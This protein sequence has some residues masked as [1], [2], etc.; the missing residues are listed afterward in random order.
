[1]ILTKVISEEKILKGLLEV[2]NLN[3]K[4]LLFTAYDAGLKVSEAVA[5][6]VTDIDSDRMQIRIATTKGKK[7]HMATLTKTTLQILTE[8]VKEYQPEKYLFEGKG[9]DRFFSKKKCSKSVW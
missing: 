7:E 8:Y 3:H 2:E 5:L 1:M 9:A 4:A 6:Q